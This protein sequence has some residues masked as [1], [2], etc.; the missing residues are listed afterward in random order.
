MRYILSIFHITLISLLFVPIIST[1]SAHVPFGVY[2]GTHAVT[3][4]PDPGSPLLG[5][6][7][8]MSFFMRDLRGEFP[9]EE[10]VIEVV[11]QK[12]LQGDNE[13]HIETL[14]PKTKSPGI[15][16]MRYRFEEAGKYRIEFLFNK[17]GESDL[18]RDA[19]FDLEVR[20]VGALG[21]SYG[22]MFLIS[23]FVAVVSFWGGMLFHRYRDEV[24]E[25]TP[26][27]G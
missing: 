16:T 17:L 9:T 24:E 18:V 8:D 20:D 6:I 12:I 11:I 27:S 21:F 4:V 14:T 22:M 7:V 10:Y 13:Q 25:H 2:A 19:V 1:A 15:Y 3:F 26:H 23:L 5:E